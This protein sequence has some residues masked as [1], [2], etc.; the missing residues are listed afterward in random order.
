MNNTITSYM[1]FELNYDFYARAI[2][3]EDIDPY[4]KLILADKLKNELKELII[5]CKKKF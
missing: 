1:L 4:S 5:I 2:Y 3:K